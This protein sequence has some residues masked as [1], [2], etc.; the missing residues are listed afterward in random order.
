[1]IEV[2]PTRNGELFRLHPATIITQVTAHSLPYQQNTTIE[3][4]NFGRMTIQNSTSVHAYM[5]VIYNSM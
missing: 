5:H 3:R 4:G 2:I 1:M